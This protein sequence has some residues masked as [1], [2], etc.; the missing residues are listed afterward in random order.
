MFMHKDLL[1]SLVAIGGLFVVVAVLIF[2]NLPGPVVIPDATYTGE[3]E[4]YGG[5]MTVTVGLT[6][7]RIV[8]IDVSHT[9]TPGIANPAIETVRANILSA[10]NVDVDGKSGATVTV[11]ALRE[12]AARA[13]AAAGWSESRIG[14][15][16]PE[17]APEI[18]P[19]ETFS[20]TAESYNGPLTVTVGLVNGEIV[21]IEVEHVDTPGIANPTIGEIRRAVLETQST[22]VDLVSGATVTSRALVEAIQDA[23][24]QAGM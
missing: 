21:M 20:A 1:K 2:F 15:E 3:A 6:D 24:A 23:L 7:D 16:I 22:D 4:S 18:E 19:D 14:M 13:L 10:Q 8:A 11:D 17:D 12:G 9:D 5:P